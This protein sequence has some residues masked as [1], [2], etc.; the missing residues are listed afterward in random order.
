MIKQYRH[1]ECQKPP[2]ARLAVF[3]LCR[4]QRGVYGARAAR[5]QAPPDNRVLIGIQRRAIRHAPLKPSMPCFLN[6]LSKGELS[7]VAAFRYHLV[8]GDELGNPGRS[9]FD[10]YQG[11]LRVI[12]TGRATHRVIPHGQ[13]VGLS[14]ALHHRRVVDDRPF[15]Q[16]F[17]RQRQCPRQQRQRFTWGLRGLLPGGRSPVCSRPS[18]QPICTAKY[19]S[20]LRAI[21][22]L[23]PFFLS[24]PAGRA[25]ERHSQRQCRAPRQG[26]FGPDAEVVDQ[27]DQALS[28]HLL[29]VQFC[30]FFMRPSYLNLAAGK[31]LFA[32]EKDTSG[33][34]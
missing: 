6:I 9:G 20:I 32:I 13:P 2:A 15:V 22:P 24:C 11:A 19:C 21:S 31:W 33:Y 14:A 5:R 17:V 30:S 3:A 7:I 28:P 4:S 18:S 23:M 29:Q 10:K 25:G 34:T 27:D 12:G 26:A 1:P 16:L 8:A